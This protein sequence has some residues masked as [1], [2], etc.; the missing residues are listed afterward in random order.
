MKFDE[1]VDHFLEQN[2]LEENRT[3]KSIGTALGLLGTGLGSAA[4][5]EPTPTQKRIAAAE[6]LAAGKEPAPKYK[7]SDKSPEAQAYRARMKRI[8]AAKKLSANP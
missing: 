6:A 8:E 1:L 2:S 5:G 3:L 4:A 7:E